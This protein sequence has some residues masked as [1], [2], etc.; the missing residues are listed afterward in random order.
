KDGA[1]DSAVLADPPSGVLTAELQPP[2]RVLETLPVIKWITPKEPGGLFQSMRVYDFGQ[3]F[4]GWVRVAVS[5]PRDEKLVFRYGTRIYSEDNS[6]DT[7][8]SEPP[9]E[10]RK[11]DAYILK[12]EGTEIWEPHFT[13]HGFRYVEVRGSTDRPAIQ[14]IE[15]RFVHSSLDSTGT[16]ESSND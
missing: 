3:N 10:G 13:L 2:E 5:G 1:W 11:S 6:L 4:S 7:R 9:D 8:S 15:G 16:F 12:G 14:K